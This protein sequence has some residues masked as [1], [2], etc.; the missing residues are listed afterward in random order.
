[1]K[2]ELLKKV[3]API[4]FAGMMLGVTVADASAA[5]GP[6]STGSCNGTWAT[7]VYGNSLGAS[8]S[9]NNS[10]CAFGFLKIFDDSGTQLDD[11]AD[12]G[13][14]VSVSEGAYDGWTV[15]FTL[16]SHSQGNCPVVHWSRSS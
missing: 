15:D 1:M 3:V 8:M 10:D 5:S 12:A 7:S 13:P 6:I 9:A 2:T 4:V 16:C 11:D 14:A